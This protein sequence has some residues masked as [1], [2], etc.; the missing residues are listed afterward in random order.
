MGDSQFGYGLVNGT[1]G[2]YDK[3]SRNWRIKVRKIEIA[4]YSGFSLNY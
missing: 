4:K 1:V 3:S 2:V